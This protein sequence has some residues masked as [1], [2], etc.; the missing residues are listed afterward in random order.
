MRRLAIL[1]ALPIVLLSPGCKGK[2]SGQGPAP[3]APPGT[4]APKAQAAPASSAIPAGHVRIG[5]LDHAVRWDD[6]DTF[7]YKDAAGAHVKARLADFNTL[8]G[9][10][11]VH[12][13]GGWTAQELYALAKRA[14]ER[15][16]EGGWLCEP[17]GGE[18]GYGRIAVR[19]PALARALIDA[20]LAHVF[21]VDGPADAELLQ[22]QAA[23]Q[24]G[25]R[26]MWEKGVP[27]GL[28]TSL[29]SAEETPGGEAV[30]DRV[31]DTATGVASPRT[32]TSR[33]EPC[34][35]VCREGSCM[36]HVPFDMRY[37]K[38]RRTCE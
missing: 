21:A 1:S 2:S 18:G 4:E 17:T 20:G 33:Y 15:A 34:Q 12:R 7:S 30:Y 22:A 14:G 8:E 25:G 9:Y 13:W 36:R 35:E 31:A 19:C 5:G 16:R 27:K 23:A 11:P 32:H 37:G 24:A 28:V 6:G 38:D 26:G 10:G 3:A 29:H